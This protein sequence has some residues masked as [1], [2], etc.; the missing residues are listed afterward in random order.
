MSA[1]GFIATSTSAWSPGVVM[2]RGRELDLE[3]RDPVQRARR[4]PDLGREV[5]QRGEVVAEHGRCAREPVARQLHPVARVAGE[6]DD[7]A[8]SFFDGLASSGACRRGSS[9]HRFGSSSRRI[10]SV[11][12][13]DTVGGVRGSSAHAD[14]TTW[15][16]GPGYLR[17]RVRCLGG[18]RRRVGPEPTSE[19]AVIAAIP[20]RL[21]CG[22][23]GS[24]RRGLR[25]G[26]SEGIVGQGDRGA[27]RRAPRGDEGGPRPTEARGSAPTRSGRVRRSAGATGIDRIDLY[28]LHWPDETGVPLEDTWGAM[29]ELVAPARS[30]MSASRTSIA[31][32]SSGA[33]PSGMWTPCSRSSP[34]WRSTSAT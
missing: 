17:D 24:T 5:R 25:G 9:P 15:V 32:S 1:A 23:D 12:P 30:G 13:P 18:G 11:P 28:Q 14:T 29:A 21:R 34:C 27:S 19:D 16:S 4:R 31:S 22:G 33:S 26:V 7:D 10:H 8:L 6:P 3:R 20:R 2:S